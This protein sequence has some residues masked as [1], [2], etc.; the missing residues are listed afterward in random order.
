MSAVVAP[1]PLAEI[2]EVCL[3][4]ADGLAHRGD[5]GDQVAAELVQPLVLALREAGV[6][7]EAL[8]AVAALDRREAVQRGVGPGE[9]VVDLA[10][11]S[12]QALELAPLQAIL[13]GLA[14]EHVHEAHE[15]GEGR[16]D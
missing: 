13:H 15:A 10:Q 16:G 9:A 14:E 5:L 1:L 4:V 8:N 7:A 11:V 12:L 6:L 2:A 3:H